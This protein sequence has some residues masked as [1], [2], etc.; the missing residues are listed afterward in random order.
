MVNFGEKLISSQYLPWAFHYLDYHHLKEILESEYKDT[1]S[2]TSLST[3]QSAI[4]AEFLSQLYTQT[5]KVA[6]FVLQ[7]EGRITFQLE[8]C[9]RNLLRGV[10][11]GSVDELV[12]MEE[13]YVAAG[14]ALLQLIRFIDLNITG[15]RKILKKHDKITHFKLSALYL[16]ANNNNNQ[17][18]KLLTLTKKLSPTGTWDTSNMIVLGNSLL[19][20]LLNYDAVTALAAA[21]ATGIEELTLLWRQYDLNH[22]PTHTFQHLDH[23]SRSNTEPNLKDLQFQQ[24]TARTD[25]GNAS[26]HGNLQ[27][28][29]LEDHSSSMARRTTS[30]SPGQILLQIHA[31]RGRLYRTSEFSKL[32]GAAL[33]VEEPILEVEDEVDSKGQLLQRPS[34]FS[35]FLNLMS[36]FL[37]MSK[38]KVEQFGKQFHSTNT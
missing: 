31:A 23:N 8:D 19:Q 4:N 3:R 6:F 11:V 1:K 13:K 16:S 9:R 21:Y 7:E 37:Y 30:N 2:H 20:P 22:A 36:T 34:S 12:S 24:G 5:E 27:A 29:M 32:M 15:F 14:L 28:M 33:L 38:W 18:A 25:K 17:D 26:S 10:D 35:N